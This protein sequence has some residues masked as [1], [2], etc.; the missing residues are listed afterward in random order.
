MIAF[1]LSL[2]CI[3]PLLHQVCVPGLRATAM[4]FYL[5]VVHT[6]GNATAPA[7]IGWLSDQTGNLRL[8]VLAAPVVALAGGLLGLWGT[9][10]VEPD[11]RAMR[12]QL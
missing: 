4:G 6:F 8:A 5:L 2:P 1:A 7:L 9:R 10:F 11:A 12:A 3:A